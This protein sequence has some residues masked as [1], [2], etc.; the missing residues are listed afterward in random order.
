[1]LSICAVYREYQVFF[2]HLSVHRR[3]DQFIRILLQSAF[4]VHGW[5][6][7]GELNQISFGGETR[8]FTVLAV[9]S[10]VYAASTRNIYGFNTF[11][12][13]S[14]PTTSDVC[15]AGTACCTRGSVLLIILPVL[16]VFG[17]SVVVLLILPARAVFRTPHTRVLQCTQHQ[18]HPEYQT[19]QYCQHRQPQKKK[20]PTPYIIE[21]R[22]CTMQQHRAPTHP[23]TV[24][25]TVVSGAQQ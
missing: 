22:T 23:P 9:M 3:F 7:E 13:L 12:T 8:V 21:V 1:M 18:Q 16:A 24:V 17:P 4:T 15:T 25:L 14:T 5:S 19:A 10:R 11:D 6:H 2:D 20:N